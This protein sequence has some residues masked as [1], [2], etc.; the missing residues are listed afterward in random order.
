MRRCF[1]LRKRLMTQSDAESTGTVSPEPKTSDD[2]SGYGNCNLITL[3]IAALAYWYDCC[4]LDDHAW[5]ALPLWER[6]R[7]KLASRHFPELCYLPE[8]ASWPPTSGTE[9]D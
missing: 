1:E 3:Y 9:E 8:E 7:V 4:E 5:S 6:E 2:E